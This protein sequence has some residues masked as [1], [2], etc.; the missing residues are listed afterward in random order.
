MANETLRI[1]DIRLDLLAYNPRIALFMDD[2]LLPILSHAFILA[3]KLPVQLQVK[4]KWAWVSA[5]LRQKAQEGSVGMKHNLSRVLSFPM[6][7]S[8]NIKLYLGND[9][10]S[11]T[12]RPHE[13]V[14]PTGLK[15]SYACAKKGPAELDQ[16]L[17]KET[18]S[19]SKPEQWCKVP[20]L[21]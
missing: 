12:T 6:T 3:H 4:N 8:H 5:S 9:H 16:L 2:I 15:K 13:T 1:R 14:E 11:Q 10:C 18:H 7:A 19:T 17:S 21:T 20:H